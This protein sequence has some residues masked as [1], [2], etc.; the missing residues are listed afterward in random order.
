MIFPENIGEFLSIDEVSLS[1]GELYTFV[2]N[3]QGKGKK[4]TLVASIK[5][6]LSNDISS[7]VNL[8]PL[9]QR[10]RVKEVTLDMAKNMEAS[11]RISFPN[12]DFVIDRFHVVKLV[13]ESLQQIRIKLR[14][15]AIDEENKAIS[16]AKKNG[17]RYVPKEFSNG[18]TV[19]QLLARSRFLLFKCSSKWTYT[20]KLR[21]KI[22]FK[23]YPKLMVAYKITMVFRNIY[24]LRNKQV[25]E[26]NF[27]NWITSVFANKMENFYTAANS[28]GTNMENI[29]N[30]FLN[31][32]TNANA[33]SFNSK[34]KLFRANLRGVSDTNFL[35]FRLQKL[36]A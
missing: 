15:K 29:T 21:A 23:E 13:I 26:R 3:K 12:A 24:E 11:M 33:E 5:G 2:T 9:E 34:I 18:D 31:R 30:F 4:G 32:N 16:E 6:T 35:L 27:I 28:I 22:L 8:K 19:K 20:Q 1:Q 36:F 17:E 25:A 10:K 7:V 14:W